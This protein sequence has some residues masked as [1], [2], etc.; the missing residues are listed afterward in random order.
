M[1]SKKAKSKTTFDTTDDSALKVAMD[2]KCKSKMPV[3]NKGSTQK[4][5]STPGKTKKG[6]NGMISTPS[7]SSKGGPSRPQTPRTLPRG[8]SEAQIESY[9]N[10]GLTHTEKSIDDL[11]QPLI[12]GG[13]GKK[14]QTLTNTELKDKL[15]LY[16]TV[17]KELKN[18]GLKVLF[19]Y[20]K[21]RDKCVAHERVLRTKEADLIAELEEFQ[22]QFEESQNK[23]NQLKE[24]LI[25]ADATNFSITEQARLLKEENSPMRHRFD[26]FA[27]ACLYV[28][29]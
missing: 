2:P 6:G 4:S 24:N 15:K 17:I 28:H 26:F 8:F 20:N 3:Y 22:E 11:M 9:F 12:L 14:Q 5:S 29:I 21:C 27:D 19:E 7:T 23:C 1:A 10:G 16:S 25:T 13:K 18:V